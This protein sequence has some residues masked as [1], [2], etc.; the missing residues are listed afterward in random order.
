MS[1]L[2]IVYVSFRLETE[3]TRIRHTT[4]VTTKNMQQAHSLLFIEG[5]KP[6]FYNV[7][8]YVQFSYLRIHNEK[9]QPLTEASL[10]EI[11]YVTLVLVKRIRQGIV[12]GHA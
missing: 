4:V 5:G 10:V 12:P 8:H 11:T 6:V 2:C 7:M 1:V 3:T 9:Y